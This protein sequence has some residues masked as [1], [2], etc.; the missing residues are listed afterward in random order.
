[1]D[2]LPTKNLLTRRHETDKLFHDHQRNSFS[3][4]VPACHLFPLFVNG[5]LLSVAVHVESRER[6]KFPRGQRNKRV[7]CERDMEISRN[8]EGISGGDLGSSYHHLGCLMSKEKRVQN[9]VRIIIVT[10]EQSDRVIMQRQLSDQLVPL[11]TADGRGGIIRC[12][13]ILYQ[14]GLPF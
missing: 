10:F 9:G 13:E 2:V 5:M 12:V 6:V 11:V 7:F 4:L 14:D 8:N 3:L 1:M